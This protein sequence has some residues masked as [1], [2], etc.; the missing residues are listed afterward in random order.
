MSAAPRVDVSPQVH[1]TEVGLPPA[2]GPNE[3]NEYLSRHAKS[4]WAASRLMPEPHRTQLAG[5]YAYCRYTD[6]LV[7]SELRDRNELM[8]ALDRWETLSANAYCGIVTGVPLLDTVMP[9]MERHDVPF[10]YAAALLRG[11]RQDVLGASYSS[12]PELL[13]Y[14]YDVASV[15]GLW[16][17]ELFGVHDNWTLAR[18]ADLGIAMQLTNIVR[19][20]GEDCARGRVYLPHDAMRAHGITPLMIEGWVRDGAS[21]VPDAYAA[22][23][24]DVMRH[25]EQAYARAGEALPQLPAFFRP[26]VA[27]ASRL[28]RGIHDVIRENGYDNITRRAVVPAAQ[29]LAMARELLAER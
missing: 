22:L 11:M 12:M 19:D 21:R 20:V 9:E 26:A 18:A 1:W 16:L 23:L 29:K 10:E 3:W 15:V 2:P 24:E 13:G 25:A 17:T 8:A 4:F 5:V 27:A 14:C 6:D 7:D 28:Y